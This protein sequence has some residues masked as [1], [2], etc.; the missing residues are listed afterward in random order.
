[1][2]ISRVRHSTLAAI[3]AP[4]PNRASFPAV[5]GFV[6]RRVFVIAFIGLALVLGGVVG[7]RLW[8]EVTAKVEGRDRSNRAIPVEVAAI[9]HG[10]IERRRT[11]SGT[12]ESLAAFRVA[13]KV[14]GRVERLAVDLAD[15]VEN[16]SVVVTLDSDLYEQEVALAE[17]DVQVAQANLAEARSG[18]EISERSTRRQTTLR[19]RGIASDAQFDTAKAEQLAADAGVAVAE[20][21]VQRARSALET[22]RIRLGYTKVRATWS[23]GDSRRVVAERMVEPGDTVAANTPLMLIVEL[24]PIQAVLYVAERDYAQLRPGQSV[25]LRTDAFANRTFHG[26][27]A[28]I[29][30]VFE[31]TSRQARVELTVPNPDHMLKPGM[32]VRAEAVL[33]RVEDTTIVP[34]GAIVTRA[35]QSVVFVIDEASMTARRRVVERGITDSGRVQVAG[36]GL[37]GRVVTLGQQLLDDGSAVILPEDTDAAS[38]PPPREAVAR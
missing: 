37:T 22:A 19:E 10:L 24:D 23:E 16:G 12:L 3:I 36:E 9:E 18:K 11:F 13:P 38:S 7:W 14:A 31:S 2:R 34:E 27:V 21:Q 17:A 30:P 25:T 8:S 28:R 6:K 26:E 5:K 33:E 4:I 35:D 15:E 29:A 1:M 20:A 32:F